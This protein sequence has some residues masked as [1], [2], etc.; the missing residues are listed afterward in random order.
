MCVGLNTMQVGGIWRM[1][2]QLPAG[3]LRV[4]A[5][6]QSA[7]AVVQF[8]AKLLVGQT[9]WEETVGVPLLTGALVGTNMVQPTNMVTPLEFLFLFFCFCLSYAALQRRA[10]RRCH[11]QAAAECRE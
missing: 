4:E 10:A 5:W 6:L 7:C 8:G 9:P 2:G 1:V 11:R 3:C